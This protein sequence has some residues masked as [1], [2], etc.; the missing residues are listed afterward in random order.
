M[1]K[2]RDSE[3]CGKFQVELRNCFSVLEDKQ[4]LHIAAFKRVLMDASDKILEYKKNKEEKW[5]TGD[6]WKKIDESKETKK[7]LNQAKLERLKDRLQTAYSEQ[8]AK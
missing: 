5:I 6:M 2:F 7:K 3:T 4:D 8:D 1:N